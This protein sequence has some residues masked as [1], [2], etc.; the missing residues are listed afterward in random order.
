MFEN[1]DEQFGSRSGPKNFRLLTFFKIKFLKINH[2]CKV[3][4][5]TSVVQTHISHEISGFAFSDIK[6]Q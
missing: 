3:Y 1:L 6:E 2:A 5:Q 4:Q